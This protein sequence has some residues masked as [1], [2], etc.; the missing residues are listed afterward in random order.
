M[1]VKNEVNFT[2]VVP[3]RVIKNGKE[4]LDKEIVRKTCLELVK[5]LS[6]PLAD[7]EKY[8]S[9]AAQLSVRD[10]DYSY[11]N[12]YKGY[13]QILPGGKLTPSSFFKILFD[14]QNRGYLV[15][16]RASEI[17]S[18]LGKLIGKA[19]REC[20][21]L[22]VPDSP[23]LLDARKNYWDT[24]QDIVN[25]MNLRIKEAFSPRT[26]KKYGKYQQIDATISTKPQKLKEK[27]E[28]KVNIENLD[29]SDR[30]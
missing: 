28:T 22:G 24:Y 10:S 12:A 9:F 16:G 14:Q 15:T 25:N 11:I 30:I 29:F 23:R 26:L 27:T 8:Q 7:N 17:M 4:I 2:G 5:E 6:G 19:K 3:V 18:E 20:N 13:T 1:Q 21:F